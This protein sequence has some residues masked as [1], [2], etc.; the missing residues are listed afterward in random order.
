MKRRYYRM[1][2]MP[3]DMDCPEWERY[4]SPF[5]CWLCGIPTNH[6]YNDPAREE[7]SASDPHR[8]PRRRPK[9]AA[10]DEGKHYAPYGPPVES[11]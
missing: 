5:L 4:Q 9:P 6:R 11:L 3:V 10:Q 7:D 1:R 2:R 8:S